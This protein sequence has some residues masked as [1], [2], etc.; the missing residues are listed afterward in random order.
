MET[1]I[2]FG[3]KNGLLVEVADVPRG[4][5]CGCICPSCKAPLRAN[6]GDKKVSYFSHQPGEHPDCQGGF[7]S[8]IHRMTKQI[9]SEVGRLTF[10]ELTVSVSEKDHIGKEHTKTA[11]VTDSTEH[12][13]D[14]VELEKRFDEIRPD[15]IAYEDGVPML[16]E[17]AVTHFTEKDKKQKIRDNHLYAIEIDLSKVYYSTTKEELTSLIYGK[18]AVKKWLSHPQAYMIKSGLKQ[19]LRHKL[20][21]INQPTTKPATTQTGKGNV[22]YLQPAPRRMVAGRYG[23]LG[24]YK[25]KEYNPRWFICEACT[26]VFSRPLSQAPYT[27]ETVTCPECGHEVSAKP[28]A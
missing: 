13:F 19:S 17:V 12:V 18:E 24:P 27:A 1:R 6:K 14:R 15:I 23:S 7:E 21:R 10:P 20:E 2:P 11:Q 26:E 9:I 5:K 16:I 4:D 22:S 25:G 8:S 28:P 3:E